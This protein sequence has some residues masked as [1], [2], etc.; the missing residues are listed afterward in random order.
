MFFEQL[1]SVTPVLKRLSV[2]IGPSRWDESLLENL[3]HYSWPILEQIEK[4]HICIRG[5]I[6]IDPTND[7]ITTKFDNYCKVLL[8]KNNESNRRFKIQW[9]EEYL[10]L[11][12][13]IEITI[14]KS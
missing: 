3:I 6:Y 8:S 5:Y 7:D 13:I 14:N 12:T 11:S 9:T 4:I 10:A 1:R 2:D